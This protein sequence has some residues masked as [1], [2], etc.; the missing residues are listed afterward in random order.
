MKSFRKRAER[1]A[2][3]QVKETKRQNP[4]RRELAW[5]RRGAKARTTKQKHVSAEWKS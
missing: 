5:L 2:E 1:E 4:L 3:A